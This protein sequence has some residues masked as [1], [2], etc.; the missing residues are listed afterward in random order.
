MTLPALLTSLSSAPP[1]V[2]EKFAVACCTEVNFRVCVTGWAL[3]AA[4]SRNAPVVAR[5]AAVPMYAMDVCS[6][7]MISVFLTPGP[8]GGEP[9]WC[10]RSG[11]AGWP[12]SERE[13]APVLCAGGGQPLVEPGGFASVGVRG[14][15]L[16]G[17]LDV[18]QA[19]EA[20][21]WPSRSGEL[22]TDRRVV[23]C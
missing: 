8:P 2:L 4:G 7:M 1:V 19:A 11:L 6:L 10:W 16:G 23:G 18:G 12:G 20:Q 15:E 21:V 3:A 5:T 13:R 22:E 14:E 17:D 9:V